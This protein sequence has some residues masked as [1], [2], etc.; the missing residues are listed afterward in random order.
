M[1]DNILKD[2]IKETKNAYH[3]N[4]QKQNPDKVRQAQ[5][6]YWKRKVEKQIQ[7]DERSKT[8]ENE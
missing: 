8:N 2:L 4:W 5:E 7:I 3:R 6:R 1:A